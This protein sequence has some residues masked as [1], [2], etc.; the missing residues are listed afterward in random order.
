MAAT[1]AAAAAPANYNTGF[2][3][4]P[5][6]LVNAANAANAVV[7][8]IDGAVQAAVNSGSS[9]I[10]D[11]WDTSWLSFKAVWAGWFKS[12]FGAGSS[13]LE[14]WLTSDLEGQLVQ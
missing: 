1:P 9:S 2:F 5:A 12:N 13:A 3:S 14:E 11:N 6:D 10:P 7:N 4:S 8:A